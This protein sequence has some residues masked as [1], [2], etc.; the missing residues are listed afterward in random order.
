MTHA[1]QMLRS[2]KLWC[3]HLFTWLFCT[4]YVAGSVASLWA[5]PPYTELV[6]S[7]PSLCYS[8]TS[9]SVCVCVCEQSCDLLV[10]YSC[11]Q[12]VSVCTPPPRCTGDKVC[13]I[14]HF[15]CT[16]GPIVIF[17]AALPLFY[18][19]TWKQSEPLPPHLPPHLPPQLHSSHKAA[20]PS[21]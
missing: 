5:C 6:P 16:F 19:S 18:I 17:M 20:E 9:C 1:L 15:L 11:L 2:R 13:V 12:V 8:D 10:Q 4:L 14:S 21:S 3:S 7:C